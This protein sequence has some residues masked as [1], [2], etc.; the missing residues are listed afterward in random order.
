M[1]PP[2]PPAMASPSL[3]TSPRVSASPET[4]PWPAR[5]REAVKGAPGAPAVVFGSLL[6]RQGRAPRVG[7]GCQ[8]RGRSRVSTSGVRG[9]TESSRAPDSGH[10]VASLRG[11]PPPPSGLSLWP[12]T[13]AADAERCPGA[14]EGLGAAAGGA[15]PCALCSKPGGH[16]RPAR[17]AVRTPAP[18]PPA[19][20]PALSPRL[21]G[22]AAWPGPG[23][24]RPPPGGPEE[25]GGRRSLHPVL[26]SSPRPGLDPS[27]PRVPGPRSPRVR[28]RAGGAATTERFIPRGAGPASPGPVLRAPGL[29]SAFLPRRRDLRGPRAR[30]T[31]SARQRVGLT[32]RSPPAPAPAPA[33]PRTRR[34]EARVRVLRVLR[35]LCSCPGGARRWSGPGSRWPGASDTRTRR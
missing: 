25:R 2:T 32:P 11:S 26:F 6:P 4:L 7:G 1:L 29:V 24:P 14:A 27:S 21:R 28:G 13:Q 33:P 34:P 3:P 30:N 16:A 5:P 20:H 10:R 22:A 35:V 23:R 18:A 17:P 12:P 19:A 8:G 9:V 31:D 15:G